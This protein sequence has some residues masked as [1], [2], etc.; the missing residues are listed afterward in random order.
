G[1]LPHSSRAVADAPDVRAVEV[2]PADA[3]AGRFAV[4]PLLPTTSRR[5][6]PART[7]GRCDGAVDPVSKRQCLGTTVSR[8]DSAPA[9]P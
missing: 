5:S 6:C 7:T 9:A 2:L 3:I 1:V 8:N 4:T